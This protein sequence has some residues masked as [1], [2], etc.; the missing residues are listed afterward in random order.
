MAGFVHREACLYHVGQQRDDFLRRG[1]YF[2]SVGV[3]RVRH[4]IGRRTD[5]DAVGLIM[6]VFI[7][8]LVF[9]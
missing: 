6:A 2:G 3:R 7:C 9:A 8:R 1:V 4:S 5:W